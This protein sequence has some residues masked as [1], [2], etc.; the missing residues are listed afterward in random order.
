[1]MR[2]NKLGI[3]IHFPFCEKKC[4]YCD[5]LS[6]ERGRGPAQEDYIGALLLEI[7]ERA[8]ELDEFSADS[9]FFGGGTPSLM[10]LPLMDQVMEQLQRCFSIAKDAEITL[11]A[12]P[13]TLTKDG[14]KSY[15]SV[16]VNRLSLGVQSFDDT[17]LLKLG[18]IHNSEQ[19]IRSYEM[20]RDAGFENINLDLIFG[21]P[22]Q[23]LSVWEDTLEKVFRLN[24]EHFSMYGLT[25]EEGTEFHRLVQKGETALCEEE[26][27]RKMYH[28][29]L[30]MAKARGYQQYEISN[31]SKPGKECQHNLKYWSFLDYLGLG[32][33]AHS[34]LSGL[35]FENT[36]RW[37]EYGKGLCIKSSHINSREDNI[38][39]YVFTNLRKATG[40]SYLEFQR[41]F[42]KTFEEHLGERRNQLNGYIREGFMEED[43]Y[44]LRLTE[45][46][47]DYSNPIMAALM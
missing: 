43:S 18:R 10:N 4:H 24:P 13:G 19:A 34:F 16:G 47:M 5:F 22:S 27:D 40:I 6:F 20:A 11:E 37:E 42:Y 32:L 41:V 8:K 25:I 23:K 46:G 31:I 21:I 1:M 44:G 38:S 33:G 7:E 12:N 2:T 9:L 28:L 30:A 35:R 14:L 15:L 36:S 45:K 3:Y 29:A 39:E 26:L 17:L